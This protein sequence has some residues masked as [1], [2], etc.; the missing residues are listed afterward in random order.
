MLNL[1]I[2]CRE[3]YHQCSS[4]CDN[5]IFAHSYAFYFNSKL[6]YRTRTFNSFLSHFRRN[7]ASESARIRA[8]FLS[9]SLSPVDARNTRRHRRPTV[10]SRRL[11]LPGGR[12]N[13]IDERQPA[14]RPKRDRGWAPRARA[15]ERQDV[16]AFGS[17]VVIPL[18]GAGSFQLHLFTSSTAVYTH[19]HSILNYYTRSNGFLRFC[20]SRFELG[21]SACDA[22]MRF[23]RFF[24]FRSR[25]D[26]N[27]FK[28]FLFIKKI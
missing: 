21:R 23:C 26:W 22:V 13:E 9:L 17:H 2:C 28:I 7:D 16:V 18:T 14:E 27:P 6:A 8:F 20:F 4:S 24:V 1:G 3:S 11:L 10:T 15:R 25:D 12:Q 19:R 5:S